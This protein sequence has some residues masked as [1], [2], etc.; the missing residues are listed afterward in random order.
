MY[1]AAAAAAAAGS[2][3]W[4]GASA[5]EAMSLGLPPPP[6]PAPTLTD[7]SGA[8]D[9]TDAAWSTPSRPV[10]LV[11]SGFVGRGSVGGGGG[12]FSMGASAAGGAGVGGGPGYA[13]GFGSVTGSSGYGA[14]FGRRYGRR[15]MGDGGDPDGAG[16]GGGVTD[17]GASF[18]GSIPAAKRLALGGGN[19]SGLALSMGD[20]LGGSVGGKSFKTGPGGGVNPLRV[21]FISVKSYGNSEHSTRSLDEEQYNNLKLPTGFGNG[22]GGASG[23]AT[24]GFHRVTSRVLSEPRLSAGSASLA[25]HVASLGGVADGGAGGGVTGAGAGGRSDVARRA[26]SGGFGGGGGVDSGHAG[27]GASAVG[28]TP[29]SR[30]VLPRGR[31]LLSRIAGGYYQRTPI[32]QRWMVGPLLGEGAFSEVR[33]VS[34]RRQPTTRAA[35]KVIPKGVKDLYD[36]AGVCREVAA[37]TR[38]GSSAPNTVELYEVTEDEQFVYIILELLG[39]GLLLPRL[40]EPEHYARYS[41]RDAADLVRSTLTALA[42]CHERHVVHRDLKPENLMFT[43]SAAGA[44]VKLTD[45]GIAHVSVA[46]ESCRQLCGTPLYVAPEVLLRL[47]YGSAADLWSLGVITHVLLVGFPPFDDADLVQLV[48]KV[49]FAHVRLTGDEWSRVTPAARAFV[50]SLLVR[51]PT[52]RLTAVRALQHE[53]LSPDTFAAAG[54]PTPAAGSAVNPLLEAA[55]I[56]IRD[57]VVRKQWKRKTLVKSP[58][59]LSKLVSLSE[60]NLMINADGSSDSEEERAAA[61]A[62]ESPAEARRSGIAR[63]SFRERQQQAL[64]SQGGGGVNRGSRDSSRSVSDG[65]GDDDGSSSARSGGG[66][67]HRRRHRATPDMDVQAGGNRPG[68]TRRRR[69]MGHSVEA[70][71]NPRS[72]IADGTQNRLPTSASAAPASPDPAAVAAPAAGAAAAGG[73]HGTAAGTSAQSSS[74]AVGGGSSAAGAAGATG[75]AKPRRRPFW[76]GGSARADRRA[77]KRAAKKA[78]D[79]AAAAAKAA[80]KARDRAEREAKAAARAADKAARKAGGGKASGGA[81]PPPAA[82]GGGAAGKAAAGPSARRPPTAPGGSKGGRPPVGRSGRSASGGGKRA[83]GADGGAASGGSAASRPAD[84]TVAAG[85]GGVSGG[86]GGVGG[87]VGGG[88]AGGPNATLGQSAVDY[89]SPHAPPDA[90]PQS[91]PPTGGGGSDGGGATSSPAAAGSPPKEGAAAATAAVTAATATAAAAAAAAVG[92]DD[93]SQGL[94]TDMVVGLHSDTVARESSVLLLTAAAAKA[95]GKSGRSADAPRGGHGVGRLMNCF[96]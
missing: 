70:S 90:A 4:D 66:R 12:S 37:L 87:G 18:S 45:F 10:N 26:N 29:R 22:G 30:P 74:D 34:H 71:S 39:G 60:R 1:A 80:A 79:A 27:S 58:I 93:V 2:D 88:S 83:G 19:S 64:S 16:G 81:P 41:E 35:M 68:G 53:W 8:D 95:A 23:T 33:L 96:F 57:F 32:S 94:S 50:A 73:V 14:G 48:Q 69:S 76:A 24:P 75:G 63:R 25:A 65:D 13:A 44:L 82:D 62:A 89:A 54:A 91:L 17:R 6:A 55:Q 85:S 92:A 15:S 86:G 47:P 77:E 3:R 46:G 36:P 43:S 5:A 49:K 56:N 38:L 72:G 21:T 78:A 7:D 67:W 52:A 42:Y 40:S 20:G 28:A 31:T 11:P 51:D 84:V 59:H 9:S 61:A